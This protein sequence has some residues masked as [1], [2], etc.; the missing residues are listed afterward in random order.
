MCEKCESSGVHPVN[1]AVLKI[2]IPI[3]YSSTLARKGGR[4]YQGNQRWIQDNPQASSVKYNAEFVS[5]STIPDGSNCV[6]GAVLRKVW[7]IKNTGTTAW[8][9]GTTIKWIGGLVAPTSGISHTQP[10]LPL[11]KAGETVEVAVE[12][13][14]P[15]QGGR[16]TGFFTLATLPL[17]DQKPSSSDYFGPKLWTEVVVVEF[18]ANNNP[19]K[20]SEAKYTKKDEP[21][22]DEPKKDDKK[23]EPKKDDKKDEPK[24]VSEP[25]K[26]EPKKTEPP[27]PPTKW[28]NELSQLKSMGFTDTELNSYLLGSNAGDVQKVVAWLISNAK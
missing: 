22:K 3:D 11:A 18:D 15:T 13:Q 16:H 6:G 23:D 12:V 9:L 27:K 8:P 1:H 25:K 10:E 17:K 21:K 24:K 5:D 2:R 28:I 26:D 14:V 4:R 20:T 19:T 7:L